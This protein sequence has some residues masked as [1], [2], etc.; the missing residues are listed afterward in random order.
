MFRCPDLNLIEKLGEA[1]SKPDPVAPVL[2][3]GMDQNCEKLVEGNP[4]RLSKVIR[5]KATS[6]KSENIYRKFWF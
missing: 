3:Q 2:S 1:N 5:F 4:E 6:T